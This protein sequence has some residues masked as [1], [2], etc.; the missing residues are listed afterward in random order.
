[1]RLA[2]RDWP[3][4]LGAV[5]LLAIVEPDEP[6]HGRDRGLLLGRMGRFSA[7]IGSLARYLDDRPDGSDRGE[8]RQVI[9]IFRGRRN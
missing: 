1:V 2:E 4:A 9:S 7:A 8:V 5:E 6:E 3:D